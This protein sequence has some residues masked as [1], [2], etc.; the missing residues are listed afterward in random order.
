MLLMGPCAYLKK[1]VVPGKVGLVILSINIIKVSK[2]RPIL[3]A[4]MSVL[5]DLFLILWSQ[6]GIKKRSSL[7]FDP[8]VV[9]R[10]YRV[11]PLIPKWYHRY[12]DTFYWVLDQ[13]KLSLIPILGNLPETVKIS[14]FFAIF[15]AYFHDFWPIFGKK[16]WNWKKIYPGAVSRWYFDPEVVSSWHFDPQ[17]VSRKY[18][19]IT[20][21][22]DH[23]RRDSLILGS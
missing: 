1:L 15:R 22:P 13:E 18:Q 19:V 10:K 20:S 2:Y 12:I 14:E 5:I 8:E 17:V 4:G 23:Y 11:D 7:Y 21:I 3:L 9:K 16:Y 6:C